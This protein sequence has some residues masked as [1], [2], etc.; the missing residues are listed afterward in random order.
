MS[1]R[2]KLKFIKKIYRSIQ[3]GKQINKY[4]FTKRCNNNEVLE[5]LLMP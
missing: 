1:N 4:H 3:F 2:L 5:T